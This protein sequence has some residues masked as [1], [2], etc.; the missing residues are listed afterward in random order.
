LYFII[1]RIAAV[2]YKNRAMAPQ[3]ID[4]ASTA[5]NNFPSATIANPSVAIATEGAAAKKPAKLLGFTSSPKAAN[6]E[7][8]APPTM[9]GIR[10]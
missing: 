7:T 10:S 8:T 1:S 5:A 3:I 6:K 9:K 4:L 2:A